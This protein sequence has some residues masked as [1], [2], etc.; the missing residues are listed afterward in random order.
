MN[1]AANH[2]VAR[3][4]IAAWVLFDWAAQPWFT[5]VTTFIF[6]PYFAARIASDPVEGQ[7]LW[8]YA[9]AAAG[10][11]IAFFSPALGAV[12]DA[13]GRRKPWIA[14][15][16][17]LLV[18]GSVALWFTGPS[19]AG[20]VIIAIVAFVVGTIGAEF[21]TV[22]TN[23]MMP[24]LVDET[25]LGRLSGAGWATGYAGGLVSLVI[26][27]GFLVG[28]PESGVTLLGIAPLFGL[29][30]STGAGD[31]AA[32]PLTAVWY[33]IFVLPLFLFT[34]DVPRRM[35]LGAAIRTGLRDLWRTLSRLRD[36]ANTARFLVGHLIYAD[37][38]VALFAFGGI[39]AASVFG[40]S[41]I[42]LGLFGILLTITGT[43]GALVGG[44]LDDRAGA[45]TVIAVALIML[46]VSSI[47]LLSIS[48]DRIAF[49]L[50]VAPPL[51]GDDL[52]ASTGERLYL[53]L[54]AVIGAVAG[55]LQS[56]SR[57][58][59]A[60]L[61]PRERATQFFGLFALS[62][63]LTS[64]AGPLTVGMLTDISGSQR[65]GL[66]VLVLFFAL[67][68]LVLAGVKTVRSS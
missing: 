23:A 46:I 43:A 53:V 36:R 67:G 19:D 52:F 7:A 20:S 18:A 56:A 3:R 50:P 57:S 22:F 25:K 60:R 28:N 12:A 21:A 4:G 65:L 62:G 17:T 39:Y 66:S 58:L 35:T 37:G 64:F 9:A 5:L 63:R 45:K 44:W 15:F 14:L 41:A 48:A 6:A 2:R 31:R 42:E 11:V 47:G 1:V 61:S 26:A 24:D 49:V 16:S 27:L 55:P 8:G 51:A 68:L 33:V 30:P 59:M 29:D 38:L 13:A 10:L 40:W 54:G 32:G 34:P